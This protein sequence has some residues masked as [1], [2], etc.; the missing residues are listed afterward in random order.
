MSLTLNQVL[1]AVS[2]G[3][4]VIKQV[5][6]TPGL[7]VLPYVSTIISAA[8]ALQA[9]EAAG[10]DIAPY[11]SAISGTFSGNVPTADDLTALDAQIALLDAQVDAPLPPAE[12]GEP[13]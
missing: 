9:A 2:A 13:A 6:S 4:G 10:R 7:N 1:D 12:P 5:A 11:I 3:L 8:S